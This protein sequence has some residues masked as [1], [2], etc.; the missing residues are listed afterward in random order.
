MDDKMKTYLFIDWDKR[1][2]IVATFRTHDAYLKYP[3]YKVGNGGR[4]V[5][6]HI[7]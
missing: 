1:V 7:T 5:I 4:R 2:T 3:Y 6:Y